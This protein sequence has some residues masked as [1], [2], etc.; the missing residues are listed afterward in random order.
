MFL[1][2][3]ILK[4]IM[5]FWSPPSGVEEHPLTDG[6]VPEAQAIE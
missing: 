4:T 2:K 3:S 1:N 6:F 5:T